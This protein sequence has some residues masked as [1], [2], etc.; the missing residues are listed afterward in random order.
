M[1]AHSSFKA[2]KWLNGLQTAGI[3]ALMLFLLY[4]LARSLGGGLA[5]PLL[6]FG[7]ALL[8]FQIFRSP[9]RLSGVVELDRYSAAELYEA[10][11]SLASRAGL[12]RTPK[13]YLVPTLIPNAFTLGSGDAASIFLTHGLLARLNRRELA[14]VIA[15]EISHIANRDLFLFRTVELVR[16]VMTLMSR[17][18]WILLFFALPFVLLSG[19]SVPLG[20]VAALIAA[21]LV[22]LVLQLALFRT[23]E[24]NA[25]IGAAELTGDPRGLA[26]ALYKIDSP[27]NGV[28]SILLPMSRRGDS[29]LFR[30]HPS[31]TERVRR[32]ERMPSV[33]GMRT[34]RGTTVYR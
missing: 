17:L 10:T 5:T 32:L 15:H 23:R 29:S 7:V 24:F 9:A 27:G 21:P 14:G 33:S 34:V 31:T 1:M 13:L 6:L 28:W 4:L 3:G 30:T 2:Q 8:A 25:D 26:S 19:S 18:G 22:S 20:L 11:G 12:S 16:Q